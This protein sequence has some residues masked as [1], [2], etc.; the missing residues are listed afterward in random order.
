M[1]VVTV[2]ISLFQN[3]TFK[4]GILDDSEDYF[5][6]FA[7]ACDYKFSNIS[8][9]YNCV[10]NQSYTEEDLILGTIKSKKIISKLNLIL[11]EVI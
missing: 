1:Y 10:K 5:K 3:G 7:E 9:F 4:N 2:K 8:D 11:Q 6:I